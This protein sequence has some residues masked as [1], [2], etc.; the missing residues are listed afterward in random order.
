M[1][2]HVEGLVRLFLVNTALSAISERS[3]S[4]LRR[5]KTYLRSTCS[6]QQPNHLAI[7]HSYQ[8]KL[9]K[10]NLYQLLAEFVAAPDSRATIFR[11]IDSD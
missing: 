10:I 5:L 9:D 2:T 8:E 4:S 3:F 7:R 1:F 6:Q 11:K